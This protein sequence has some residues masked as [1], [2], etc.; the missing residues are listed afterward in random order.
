MKTGKVQWE[1][2]DPNYH[3]RKYVLPPKDGSFPPYETLSYVWGN[4]AMTAVVTVERP[5][6]QGP[7]RIRVTKS[8]I[9]A[10]RYLRLAQKPRTL[11][12]DA[13][14]LNQTDHIE[15]S[16]Q[17]PRMGEIYRL[18]YTGTAWLG[19]QGNGSSQALSTLRYLGSQVVAE[20]DAGLLFC[21]PSAEEKL[22]FDSDSELPYSETTWDAVI[23]L[24]QRPWFTRL[25]VVQE[26][27][28]GA[29]LQCGHDTLS[30]ALFAEAQYCLYSKTQL[31]TTLRPTM[32]QVDGTLSRFW[33]MALPRLLYRGATFKQCE[34]PRDKIYGLLGLAPAKFVAGINVNYDD[35]NTA[36][37]V[38][39]NAF[40]SHAHS[41]Q[42]LEHFQNCFTPSGKRKIPLGP[43]WVP[44]WASDCPGETYV[45]SQFVAT[46][47][48]A[49]YRHP[50][51]GPNGGNTLEV[52]GVRFGGINEIT[53]A[54]PPRLD[55]WDAIQ[56]VRQ[57]Q[58]VDLDTATYSPTGESKRKAYAITLICN[59]LREREPDWI[60][61]SVD[62][63]ARQEFDEA[64]FGEHASGQEK[65]SSSRQDVADALQCC[66]E[67]LFFQTED[68]YMG[69]APAD[70]QLGDTVAIFLGAPNALILR[71]SKSSADQFTVVGECFVYGLHDAIAL[72][73]ALPHSWTGIAAWVHGDRRV[74]RYLNTETKEKTMEDPRLKPS[75]QWER[76]ERELDRDDPTI[77]D[78]FQ[79]KETGEVINYDPRLEP[80]K[81]GERGVE[82]TWFSLL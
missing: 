17:V 52:L 66:G 74:I 23:A 30:L 75:P 36:A 5:E 41:S 27:Q 79:H 7:A 57:W 29:V 35:G 34:D 13:L 10:L 44:D 28:P 42:R 59:G 3:P 78:F 19:T 77:Y 8:L 20:G 31:P 82:L 24:L 14:C 62:E 55:T 32:T 39:K 63:W 76:V 72:L 64:L 12:I 16:Q 50:G 46:T 25:W 51:N 49:H 4:P 80:E 33:V 1:H 26:L 18:A 21:S 40:L 9:T 22:W 48:R 65:P 2:P 69:L 11:W 47:S 67:R 38:Y 60:V 58:P 68:G 6:Q 15:L 61:S 45:P 71:P 37:D 73:G 43:S 56:R 70:T 81:L 53:E 54:L